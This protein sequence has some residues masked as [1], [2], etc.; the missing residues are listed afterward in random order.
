MTTRL[1]LATA[2]L[3]LLVAAPATAKELATVSICGAD[4]CTDVTEDASHALV[5]GGP[6]ADAPSGRQPYFVVRLGIAEPGGKVVHR[7]RM[8]WLP[9]AGLLRGE[10]GTWM[11]APVQM[12]KELRK[13]TAGLAPR[14]ATYAAAPKPASAAA[15]PAP[16]ATEEGGGGP[17]A[18][19]I[20]LPALA[21][22]GLGGAVARRRRARRR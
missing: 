8:R 12:R 9:E 18:L 13:L 16:A 1:A 15:T 3:A 20:G 22:L 7:F 19:A 11:T 6:V 14:V 2:S 4:R 21:A 10:D 5:E 17:S